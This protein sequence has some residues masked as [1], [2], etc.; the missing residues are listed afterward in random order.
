MEGVHEHGDLLDIGDVP[1]E[2]L[3]ARAGGGAKRDAV[4]VGGLTDIA[5]RLQDV[6]R[7]DAADG[8]EVA[9]A[10]VREEQVVGGPCLLGVHEVAE[11][12]R[13]RHAGDADDER[14]GGMGRVV[15]I[16][17]ARVVED[18]AQVLQAVDVAGVHAEEHPGAHLI[19]VIGHLVILGIE[20][21]EGL[22]GRQE[23]LL[24]RG[25]G[26]GIVQRDVVEGINGREH[27]LVP[28]L[29]RRHHLVALHEGGDER[30]RLRLVNDAIQHRRFCSLRPARA[31]VRATVPSPSIVTALPPPHSLAQADGPEKPDRDAKSPA[32]PTIG[33]AGPHGINQRV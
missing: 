31:T 13:R 23:V 20:L 8:N 26:R 21:E 3:L 22:F 33:A 12:V 1:V 28:P 5:G 15:G 32:A 18:A 25:D 6:R 27:V 19:G 2:G 17:I 4:L 24:G 16:G 9:A 11:A 14:G 10:D 29:D 30:R 7:H